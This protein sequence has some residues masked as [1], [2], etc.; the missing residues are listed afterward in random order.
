MR[1]SRGEIRSYNLWIGRSG[2]GHN[3][4]PLSINGEVVAPLGNGPNQCESVAALVER[5]LHNAAAQSVRRSGNHV[6]FGGGPFRL[7][8]STNIFVAVSRGAIDV[9]QSDGKVIIR[10]SLMLSSVLAVSLATSIAIAMM[11]AITYK[12]GWITGIRNGVIALVFIFGSNYLM[13]AIRVPNWLRGVATN[14]KSD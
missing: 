8:L 9:I 13:T 10:Y 14:A 3:M 12:L 5:G 7:V 11:T 6:D 2:I 1:D 4:F